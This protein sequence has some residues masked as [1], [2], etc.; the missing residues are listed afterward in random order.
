MSRRRK[1]EC[2]MLHAAK[3][4]RERYG[5]WLT[6][7]DIQDVVRLIQSGAS[8]VVGEQSN[9]RKLHA[10]T[11]AGQELYALYDKRHK[12]VATFLTKEMVNATW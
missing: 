7:A 9:V 11:W 2:M 10:V 3:R 6:P 1:P 12:M 4:A 8:R 5:L